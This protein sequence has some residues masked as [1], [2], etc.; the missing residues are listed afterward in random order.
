[1]RMEEREFSLNETLKT[2]REA[3]NLIEKSYAGRDKNL[4]E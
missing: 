1:M 2:E 3:S 4:M